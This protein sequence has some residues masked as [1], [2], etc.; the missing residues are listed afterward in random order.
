MNSE[1]AD[2]STFFEYDK[3]ELFSVLLDLLSV[4]RSFCEKHDLK[5]YAQG[6]TMLGAVR[7]HGFIPWDD[8]I[9]L[10]M[11]REDFDK[12]LQLIETEKMPKPYRFLTP[13][14]DAQY[15]K[16]LIRL[17]N[18]NTTAISVHDAGFNYN[19]GIFI[20][21]FPIDSIPDSDRE[22]ASH[23]KRMRMMRLL[24]E[25]MCRSSMG[26]DG[27]TAL[28]KS[29]LAAYLILNLFCKAK[30]L[31]K[32][33]VFSNF[34]KTASAYEDKNQKRVCLSTFMI[35]PKYIN[36]KSDYA[37]EILEMPFENTTIP[38]PATY[39]RILRNHY[40]DNYMTPVRE[41]TMHGDT[42]FSMNIPYKEFVETY[43]DELLKLW[44]DYRISRI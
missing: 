5:F 28:T 43:H 7:H 33:R 15:G 1:K 29:H 39:D 12:L 36:L 11:M 34:N 27:K 20:D 16:G 8:D 31:T 17:C 13:L 26:S 19:R 30:I 37:V 23:K 2:L 44:Q 41:K 42:L 22:L 40:G 25:A 9:D 3:D 24:M 6:G 35:V 4:F 10:A 32:E 38:V 18:V 14:T 21:I